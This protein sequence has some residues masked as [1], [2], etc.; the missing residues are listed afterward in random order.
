MIRRFVSP[1]ATSFSFLFKNKRCFAG[2]Q[3]PFVAIIARCAGDCVAAVF[4]IEARSL[5]VS[6]S[7]EEA[8]KSGSIFGRITDLGMD[9]YAFFVQPVDLRELVQGIGCV[10]K[11]EFDVAVLVHL[12]LLDQVRLASLLRL[13]VVEAKFLLVFGI[14]DLINAVLNIDLGEELVDVRAGHVADASQDLVRLHRRFFQ[15]R[16]DRRVDDRMLEEL[17]SC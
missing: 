4:S 13:G 16:L 17:R 6:E 7:S 1:V 11:L 12:D 2:S 8:S 10:M 9:I 3:P 14:A 15:L 5:K